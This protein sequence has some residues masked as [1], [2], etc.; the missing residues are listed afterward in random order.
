MKILV[1]GGAGYIGSHASIELLAAGH[2]VVLLDNLS[3]ASPA[4]VP[5]ICRIAGR[6]VPFV[7]CDIRD[8]DGLA[9]LF[10]DNDFDAVFHFAA[11]KAVGESVAQPL[12]YYDNNVIGSIRLF[13][14]MAEGGVKTLVYSSTAAVYGNPATTPIAENC[15]TSPASPYA[16]TKLIGEHLLREM[17]RADPEWR[18]SILRYFNA[19]GAHPSGDIGEHPRGPPNN[20]LP[21]VAQ[22]A[23][24]RRERLNVFGDDYPTPDGT[25]IRDYLHVVDLA[26]AHLA[27]LGYITGFPGVAVHNLGTGQ[28]RSVFEVLRAFEAASGRTVPHQVVDRRPGDVAVSFADPTRARTQLGWTANHGLEETCED[29]WRW[30]SRHPDGFGEG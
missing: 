10:A 26:R 18:V 3:N 22:V 25:G 24:G 11:L 6:D 19:V 4:A 30:Q 9:K 23:A 20:L 2:H 15:P 28:G 17:H 14:R 21:Y 27:A 12:R 5:A 16:R 8:S 29:L 1:T 7:D 13:D